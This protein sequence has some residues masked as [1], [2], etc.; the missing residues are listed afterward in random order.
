MSTHGANILWERGDANFVDRKYSRAHNWHFDGGATVLASSAP[1]VIRPPLSDPAGVDPE[2]A[3]V[4]ALGSCHMMWFLAL[5]AKA[6]HVVERY[7][8][9]ASGTL[10]PN[11]SGRTA[12]THITLRPKVSY[13]KNAPTPEQERALHDQAHAQ[14]NIANSLRSEV[15]IEPQPQR[16][17]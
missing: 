13:A 11:A 12:L 4:A 5:A 10:A 1:Q 14:C 2:E 8:D 3:V 9:D 15:H 7:E 17:P 6:G 16:S